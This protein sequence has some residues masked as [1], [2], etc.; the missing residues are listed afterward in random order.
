MNNFQQIATSV[1]VVPLLLAIKRMP[2]LWKEDT[3]LRKYPQGPFGSVESII[4]R[5]PPKAVFATKEEVDKYLSSVDQHENAD[6]PPYKSLP[7]ARLLVMSLMGS[8][9]AG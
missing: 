3:Y 5:F 4:L 6:Y 8:G 2:E 1:D 9:W 7:E